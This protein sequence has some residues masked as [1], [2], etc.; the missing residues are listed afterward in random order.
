VTPE[1]HGSHFFVR[2]QGRLIATPLFV[3][4]NI[5]NI[6]DVVFAVDSIRRSS[7]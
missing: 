6:T 1:L 2:Q 4:L 3:A 7:P 5:V